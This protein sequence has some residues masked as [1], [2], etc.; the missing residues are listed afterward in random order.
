MVDADSLETAKH[1][2][3]RNAIAYKEVFPGPRVEM[4]KC[5]EFQEERLEAFVLSNK[6]KRVAAFCYQLGRGAASAASA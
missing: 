1:K 4:T 2:A 3:P 5:I 6:V